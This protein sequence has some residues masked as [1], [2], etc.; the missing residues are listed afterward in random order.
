MS[1]NESPDSLWKTV[2]KNF[3]ERKEAVNLSSEN[4]G[5]D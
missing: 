1:S 3:R 5:R 4:L 2:V